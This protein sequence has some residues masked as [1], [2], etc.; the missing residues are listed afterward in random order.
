[1]VEFSVRALWLA[2]TTASPPDES[3]HRGAR[4]V[5]VPA[6]G[7]REA[8]AIEE[9]VIGVPTA[10]LGC[11]SR[12]SGSLSGIEPRFSVTRHYHDKRITYHRC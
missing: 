11:G 8:S 5:S 7:N 9:W 1:M 3:P 6:N 10:F 4:P 12:F 2:M